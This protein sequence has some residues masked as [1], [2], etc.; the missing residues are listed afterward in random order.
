MAQLITKL[1]LPILFLSGRADEI[2]PAHMMTQVAHCAATVA[3]IKPSAVIYR[4]R[5][6]CGGQQSMLVAAV[7]L[8][9]AAVRS[10][11]KEM[12]SFP[13]G[14]H[15]STCLSRGYYDSMKRFVDRVLEEE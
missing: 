3:Y 14:K 11:G 15:N 13:K 12:V 10:I 9:K 7:Q 2:V 4:L 6:A 5:R 1:R 8:H